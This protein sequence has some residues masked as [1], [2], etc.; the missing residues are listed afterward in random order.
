MSLVR[1]LL[2]PTFFLTLIYASAAAQEPMDA[3]T[4]TAAVELE[5]R[6]IAPCCWR[7]TLDVHSSPTATELRREIRTRLQAG[8]SAV[9]IES[10]LVARYGSKLRANLPDK[11]GYL[12]F[13]LFLISGLFAVLWLRIQ[14]LPRRTRTSG[15]AVTAPS[16]PQLTAVP[17]PLPP[18]SAA[19]RQQLED[20]LDDDLAS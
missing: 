12:L 19:A 10:T 11:L 20:R 18:L 4:T 5:R 3:A 2:V 17:A 14:A 1:S 7:E 15:T 9:A 13:G 8:E 16:E 6:L